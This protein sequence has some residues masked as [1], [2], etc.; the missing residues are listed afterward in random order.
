MHKGVINPLRIAVT[1]HLAKRLSTHA[2]VALLTLCFVI[3]AHSVGAS[4]LPCGGD[5]HCH[6][7][8]EGCAF[9]DLSLG[10][11][12]VVGGRMYASANANAGPHRCVQSSQ[13][14]SLRER[15]LGSRVVAEG[16]ICASA[17]ANT[18]P[19]RGGLRMG[20]IGACSELPGLHIC[21]GSANSRA[22]CLPPPTPA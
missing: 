14:C 4:S 11:R 2:L 21:L 22:A 12:A 9:T 10:S 8:F 19:C 17:I 16:R 5:A 7:P 20:C 18:G 13:G 1:R 15:S 6:T 3:H